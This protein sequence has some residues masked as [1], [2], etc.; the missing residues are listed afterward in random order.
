MST[1]PHRFPWPENRTFT[2]ISDKLQ[3]LCPTS[4]HFLSLCPPNTVVSRKGRWGF[5][6]LL[7]LNFTMICK[8]QGKRESKLP[9]LARDGS[10]PEAFRALRSGPPPERRA[11]EHI[12]H[13]GEPPSPT[14]HQ[15]PGPF[16]P[17]FHVNIASCHLQPMSLSHTSLET[18]Q[19]VCSPNSLVAQRGS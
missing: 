4:A 3:P 2:L 1:E 8:D 11:P 18:S 16:P 14:R 17:R 19:N 12:L 13:P 6:K 10:W 15:L 9:P 7:T 5:S